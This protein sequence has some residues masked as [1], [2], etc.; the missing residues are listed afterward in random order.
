MS[1][2]TGPIPNFPRR[3]HTSAS[4]EPL[5]FGWVPA[6]I[7]RSQGMLKCY[8]PHGLKVLNIFVLLFFFQTSTA[9][10]LRGE[11]PVLR[12]GRG[13]SNP[14]FRWFGCLHG[15]PGLFDGVQRW[16][17]NA[18]HAGSGDLLPAAGQVQIKGEKDASSENRTH[19]PLFTRQV[20]CLWAIEAICDYFRG[21]YFRIQENNP[22]WSYFY[23]TFKGERENLR[24]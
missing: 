9:R 12:R 3:S 14:V 8:S 21:D 15:F 17:P 11:G 13:R 22:M 6:R 19:D 10:Q 2:S 20:L 5:T 23:L 4:Q 18:S 24:Y 1:R 7:T 16:Q